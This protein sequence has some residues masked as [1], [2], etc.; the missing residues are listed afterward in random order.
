MIDRQS[1]A[2][3]S[4]SIPKTPYS[5]ILLSSIL[6]LGFGIRVTGL[7]WGQAYCH[8]LQNDSL[9]A[10]QVAV[11]YSRGEAGAQYI[12]QPNYNDYAKLPGPLWA[13]FCCEGLRLGKGSIE[14]AVWLVILLNTGAIYLTYV[15]AA[16]TI[17]VTAALWAALFMAV[18][19]SAVFFST[20]LLNPAVMPFLS[21]LLLLALWQTTQQDRS[22]AIFW[23]PFLPL[24]MMQF[25]MTGLMLVPVAILVLALAQVRLNLPWLAIGAIAGFCLYLPYIHGEMAHG[26]QNTRGMTAGMSHQ[27]TRTLKVFTEPP[28]YLTNIWTPR[29]VYLPGEYC[30]MARACFGTFGLFLAANA[31]SVIAAGFLV[32]G[33]FAA[34]KKGLRGIFRSPRAVFAQSTGTVFLAIAFTVPLLLN[35]LNGRTFFSRYCLALLPALFALAG[36]G[37]CYWL[38]MPRFRRLVL[39]I[40][41]ASTCATAWFMPAMFRFQKMYIQESSRFVPGLGKLE[42]VYQ[43][44][45]AHAGRNRRVQVE[46]A[47]YL[48]SLAAP[49]PGQPAETSSFQNKEILCQASE[50]CQYVAIREKQDAPLP[51]IPAPVVMYQL[52]PADKVRPGDPAVAYYGNGIALIAQSRPNL[53]NAGGS[54][55]RGIALETVQPAQITF[56]CPDNLSL[57]QTRGNKVYNFSG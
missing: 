28:S 23:I 18:S 45:K 54:S 3:C 14:G 17:G 31:L 51:D 20:V 49:P 2:A 36:A 33:A 34:V 26:W 41:L 24:A 56:W 27:W 16:R 5:W 4:E 15:L 8:G 29:W 1:A 43:S 12:G 35:F 21:G 37:A 7:W 57:M 47:D 10:Y 30:A 55:G 42:V 53:K 32:S 52:L 25:H 13:L 50:I 39:A 48:K 40:L 22:K 6:L 9:E 46:D 19:P 38:A 44:L 11:D